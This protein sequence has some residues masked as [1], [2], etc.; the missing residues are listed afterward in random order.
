L[1]EFGLPT[2]ERVA[3]HFDGILRRLDLADPGSAAPGQKRTSRK[4]KCPATLMRKKP[5][6]PRRI[7]TS[8]RSISPDA[9]PC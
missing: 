2:F 9:K 7:H 1:Q 4:S 8:S 6:L 3:R 5:R